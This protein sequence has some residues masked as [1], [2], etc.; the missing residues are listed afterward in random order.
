MGVHDTHTHTH[1]HTSTHGC[2]PLLFVM[3]PGTRGASLDCRKDST[4]AARAP[5]VPAPRQD[6]GENS[7]PVCTEERAIKTQ[8]PTEAVLMYCS[9]AHACVESRHH[10]LTCTCSYLL[11][12]SPSLHPA[13][14]PPSSSCPPLSKKHSLVCR[15]RSWTRR[16]HARRD[17][18]SIWSRRAQS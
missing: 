1:T 17:C 2:L 15:Q 13:P 12:S 9:E 11:Y 18:R 4:G 3:L 16:V 6:S 7:D 10:V 14:P 8:Q 5:G